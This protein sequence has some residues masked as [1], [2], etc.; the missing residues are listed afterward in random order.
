M[1]CMIYW[2]DIVYIVWFPQVKIDTEGLFIYFV[3]LMMTLL[4]AQIK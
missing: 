1:C 2:I 4:V 3:G